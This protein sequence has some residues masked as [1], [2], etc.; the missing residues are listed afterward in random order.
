MLKV[1]VLK[2]RIKNAKNLENRI[3][4]SAQGYENVRK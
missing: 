4:I 3:S 1:N 2:L